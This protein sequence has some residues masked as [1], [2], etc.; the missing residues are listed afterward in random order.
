[1]T[2]ILGEIARFCKGCRWTTL[3]LGSNCTP[4]T[5][6]PGHPAEGDFLVSRGKKSSSIPPIS[7]IIAGVHEHARARDPVDRAR[8]EFANRA[9]IS[10][11]E[12]RYEL[13]PDRPGEAGED[14]T[15]PCVEPSGFRKPKPTMPGGSFASAS[16]WS[17]RSKTGAEEPRRDFH[18][19]I[20][21]QEPGARARRHPA[22]TPA[23][24]P[25]LS[26]GRSRRPAGTRQ[27]RGT[28]PSRG[29]VDDH[30]LTLA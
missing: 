12:A 8:T 5:P 19:R 15:E 16:Y 22:L 17:S 24:K 28:G 27:R 7:A 20:E 13:L 11:A 10:C 30:D 14:P 1:M 25:A 4:P 23:A 6:A 18:V 3:T 29:I 26:G 9:G 21:D 2:R